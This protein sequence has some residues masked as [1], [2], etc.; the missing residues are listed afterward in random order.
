[1]KKLETKISAAGVS[2]KGP[3]TVASRHRPSSEILE[4]PQND[5]NLLENRMHAIDTNLESVE[6]W[7]FH[8]QTTLFSDLMLPLTEI[9]EKAMVSS[10]GR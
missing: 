1:M 4:G 6:H 10:T 5:R 9:M 3:L 7:S 8:R 2:E